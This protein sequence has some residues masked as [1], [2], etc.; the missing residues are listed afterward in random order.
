M[1]TKNNTATALK[2]NFAALSLDDEVDVNTQ[3]EKNTPTPKANSVLSNY[4]VK[5]IPFELLETNRFQSQ[6]RPEGTN[7]DSL[8]ELAENIA[9]NGFTSVILVRPHPDKPGKYELG[10]GHRRLAA[11]KIAVDLDV[12][13]N[14]VAG[15]TKIPARIADNISDGEW[16][17]IAVSENL[18]REDLTPLAIAN[19]FEAIRSQNPGLSLAD[20]ARRVGRSKSWVQRYD[21]INGAPSYLIKMIRDKPDSLE[22]LFILKKIPDEN[23]QRQL[24]VQVSRGQLTLGALKDIVEKSELIPSKPGT[25]KYKPHEVDI[26]AAPRT[27]T[28]KHLSQLEANLYY[29]NQHLEKTGYKV[30]FDERNKFEAVLA[31]LQELLSMTQA[32]A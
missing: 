15:W 13:G 17:D 3:D 19:S 14:K 32:K 26:Q 30:S 8:K 1:A 10:H 28:A 21:A 11:L 5:Q 6:L 29:L 24:A 16:L 31:K 7:E 27:A 25:Q 23:I 12:A 22:H 18:S 2:R 4:V 20:I 9:Q